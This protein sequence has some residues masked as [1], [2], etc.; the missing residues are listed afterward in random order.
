MRGYVLTRYGDASAMQLRDVPVPEPAR[1]EVQIRVHAAGL[2]PVDFKIRQGSLRMIARLPLPV[3]AGNE[4]AGVVTK[5]GGGVSTFATGDRVFARV[6]K[7]KLGAFAEYAVVAADLVA[8]LPADLDF[9]QAAGLPLAGLTALQALRDELR[10]THGS[11]VLI[12]GGAG[13]VGTLAIQLA[14][15]LGAEVTT[16]ASP[17]GADLVRRL[18]AHRVIDYTRERFVEVLDGRPFDGALDLVGGQNLVDA[19]RVVRPGGTVV[20]VTGTPEPRTARQD[21]GR[22]FP[23]TTLFWAASAGIRRQARR[24]GVTYR[25]MFM[26][27]HGADL[28]QLAQLVQS[29]ELEVIVDREFAF[30]QIGAALEYLEQGRAKGKV[31][32]RLA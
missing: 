23:L 21:L 8:H 24:H 20:A 4:L 13:G 6:D 15:W 25:Y 5:V 29:K 26:R 14:T 7:L 27:P 2:N 17:R 10:L 12:T 19:F 3:V 28:A 31:V 1:G 32:V 30:D 16:T 11:R 9:T 22:G 18:G